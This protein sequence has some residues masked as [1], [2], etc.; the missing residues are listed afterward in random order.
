MS[1]HKFFQ[2][3]MVA[4]GLCLGLICV[5]PTEAA[6][7]VWLPRQ[8]ALVREGSNIRLDIPG[9]DTVALRL[10]DSVE[11]EQRLLSRF[12]TVD[13]LPLQGLEGRALRG[14]VKWG[15]SSGDSATG[16]FLLP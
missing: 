12:A 1:A 2:N 16:W 6:D 8:V 5:L 11:V 13:A 15:V 7:P 3:S 9:V 14:V 10:L 4:A